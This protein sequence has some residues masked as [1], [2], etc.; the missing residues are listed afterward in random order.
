MPEVASH[1]GQHVTEGRL[2]LAIPRIACQRQLR[3][4]AQWRAQQRHDREQRQQTGRG[5][6]N[7]LIRRL[8]LG[9]D[10]EMGARFLEADLDLPVLHEPA[11]DPQ[12]LLC[13]IGAKCSR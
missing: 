10:T 4:T 7:G 6:R 8:A 11:D 13:G 3:M 5:A 12:G 9:L 1:S 2:R